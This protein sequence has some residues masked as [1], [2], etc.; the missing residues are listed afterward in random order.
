MVY[1]LAAS[2]LSHAL[3]PKNSKHRKLLLPSVTAI[4]GLSFNLN[5]RN[6]E[7]NNRNACDNGQLKDR[8][9]FVIWH[10]NLNNYITPQKRTKDNRPCDVDELVA[11][12]QRH[13]D[14]IKAIVYCQRY[15][16]EHIFEQLLKSGNLVIQSTKHL[17]SIRTQKNTNIISRY[18]QLHQDP[19]IALKSLGLVLKHQS[20]LRKL[21]KE[22]MGKRELCK[23]Q[24]EQG[25]SECSVISDNISSFSSPED[26]HK[27]SAMLKLPRCWLRNILQKRDCW[28]PYLDYESNVCMY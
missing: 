28:K 11:F 16:A 17:V 25:K 19:E 3:K 21:L 6:A 15:G 13:S 7:K 4:P 23:N 10:D 1:I 8:S 9:D 12:L 24:R 5:S 26:F 27:P 22:N 18:F 20:K 14:R 2:S